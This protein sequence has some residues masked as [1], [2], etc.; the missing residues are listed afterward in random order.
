MEEKLEN[1]KKKGATVFGHILC[2]FI[3]YLFGNYIHSI[4]NRAAIQE[5]RNQK[6][7]ECNIIQKDNELEIPTAPTKK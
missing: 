5:H 6:T 7:L 2:I 4:A 3:G 1:A